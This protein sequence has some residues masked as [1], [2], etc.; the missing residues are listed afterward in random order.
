[1][2]GGEAGAS[3]GPR[4]TGQAPKQVSERA[5]QPVQRVREAE[6]RDRERELER[7]PDEKGRFQHEVIGDRAVLDEPLDMLDDGEPE[8]GHQREQPHRGPRAQAIAYP[9][10]DAREQPGGDE[11]EPARDEERLELEVAVTGL[12]EERLAVVAVGRRHAC[13]RANAP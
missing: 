5:P 1:M 2:A 10:R 13:R 9:R 12:G 11:H 7:E 3:S 4:R 8:H 6:R